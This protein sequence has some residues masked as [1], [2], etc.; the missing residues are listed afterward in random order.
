[1]SEFTYLKQQEVARRKAERKEW[2]EYRA[3]LRKCYWTRP[4]RHKYGKPVYVY[5]GTVYKECVG[6]GKEKT[7]W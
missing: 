5:T 3:K 6:C 4:F 1:M 2:R 7:L